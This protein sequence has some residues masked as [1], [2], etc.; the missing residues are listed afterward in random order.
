MDEELEETYQELLWLFDGDRAE[1]CDWLSLVS[2]LHKPLEG[3]EEL[4]CEKAEEGMQW[5][6]ESKLVMD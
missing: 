6:R 5:R 3:L 4:A 2:E 1:I